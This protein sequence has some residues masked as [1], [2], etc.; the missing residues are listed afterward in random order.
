MRIWLV[1]NRSEA[2]AGGLEAPLRQL[3]DD[4]SEGHVLV[5]VRPAG[6]S[7]LRD[8][9][10][11]QLDAVVIAEPT[12]PQEPALSELM[13]LDLAILVVTTAN[14]CERFQTL[15]QLH[16]LWFIPP[17]PT[18]ETLRLA[19]RGLAACRRR[20]S[21]WKLQIA[22]LQQRLS[23]RVVI[24][25]AKGVLVRQLGISEE[26]AYKRLRVSSRRQRRQI[27]DIAQSLLD[28]QSLLLPERNG[29]ANTSFSE[30]VNESEIGHE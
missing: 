8:L 2:D 30:N 19:V 22:G 4:L 14:Q 18:L 11:Q 21:Q 15:A 20:Q 5:G 23:D 6:P 29:C 7:V 12:W 28:T 26:E 27:R 17:R 3:A 9:R 10:G 1:E 25:R 13:E 24:E 16:S